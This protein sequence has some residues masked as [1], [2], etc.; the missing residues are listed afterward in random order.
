MCWRALAAALQPGR[1][2]GIF[3]E[4]AACLR[5]AAPQRQADLQARLGELLATR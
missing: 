1:A 2:A 5:N 3:A 4:A